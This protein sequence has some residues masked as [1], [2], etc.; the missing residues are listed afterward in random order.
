MIVF[1]PNQIYKD[2]KKNIT[3]D[4][5]LN[6]GRKNTLD[7]FGTDIFDDIYLR[8]I[9]VIDDFIKGKIINGEIEFNNLSN[10]NKTMLIK[11]LFSQMNYFVVNGTFLENA[12]VEGNVGEASIN[13]PEDILNNYAVCK[14]AKGFLNVVSFFKSPI[15]KS[16]PI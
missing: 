15:Y 9:E 4:M 8:S 11:A 2:F 12:P 10:V 5:Y 6:D 16:T 1:D 3:K 7:A 14:E 13:N